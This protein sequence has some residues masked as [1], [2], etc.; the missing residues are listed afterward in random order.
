MIIIINI[1]ILFMFDTKK[2]LLIIIFKFMN[3]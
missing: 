2:Y 1:I 3:I